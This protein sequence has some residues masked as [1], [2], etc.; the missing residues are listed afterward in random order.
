MP[1]TKSRLDLLAYRVGAR[2]RV[3]LCNETHTVDLD[4]AEH[5]VPPSGVLLV[6]VLC[7]GETHARQLVLGIACCIP[8][9]VFVQLVQ[10]EVL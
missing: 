3:G 8:Q 10:R 2:L 9:Q 1:L 7:P 5:G 6:A 4:P